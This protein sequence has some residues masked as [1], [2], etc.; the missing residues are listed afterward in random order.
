M[1]EQG[2]EEVE[3]VVKVILKMSYQMLL[4]SVFRV[5]RNSDDYL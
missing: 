1:R 4:L 5:L 2:V 3:R